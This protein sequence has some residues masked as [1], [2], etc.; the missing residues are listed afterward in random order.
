[1]NIFVLSTNPVEAAKM[2]CNKHVVKMIVEST[3]LLSNVVDG[4]YKKTHVKHPCS[5]WAGKNRT[6]FNWLVRHAL[7]L[8]GEYTERYH[9]IH[10]CQSIIEMLALWEERLPIGV[11]PFV[12]C[13]PDEYKHSD[14]VIAYQQYYHSKAY[15][16]KWPEG[17]V[18]YW[19]MQDWYKK[20]AKL[21]K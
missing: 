10:K 14:P 17:K 2:Q 20:F 8:C 5:I 16:A 6:N 7:A 12:Q 9:K 4:P 13:M 18:P 21:E 11:S 15:F 3:Q 19:W 1:M